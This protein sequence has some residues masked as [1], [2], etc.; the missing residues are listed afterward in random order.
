MSIQAVVVPG[1]GVAAAQA[2]VDSS[3][4]NQMLIF[5]ELQ[6][7]TDPDEMGQYTFGNLPAP[8]ES[9][10]DPDG[11]TPV[12]PDDS[13]PFIDDEDEQGGGGSRCF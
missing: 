12:D 6:A 9:E 5:R 11:L 3:R 2:G 8:S 10:E 7:G 1:M 13:V 4:E